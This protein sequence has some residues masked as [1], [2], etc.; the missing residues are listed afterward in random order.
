MD[1]KGSGFASIEQ[2]QVIQPYLDNEKFFNEQW[3]FAR[4]HSESGTEPETIEYFVQP[5]AQWEEAHRQRVIRHFK[6][7]DLALRYSREAAP[8]VCVLLLQIKELLQIQLGLDE[9]KQVI[10]QSGISKSPFVNHWER[11]LCVTLMDQ[12]HS[13]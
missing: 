8:R 10:L 3:I 2:D 4:Y 12:L 5:P 1:G 6:D 7:F 11:I 13:L 9:A